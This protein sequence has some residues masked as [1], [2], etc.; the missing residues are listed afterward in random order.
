MSAPDHPTSRAERAA[1]WRADAQVFRRYGS[2]GRAVMLERLAAEWEQ[3]ASDDAAAVVDLTTAAS[4][5]GRGRGI[6]AA[7]CGEIV[8]GG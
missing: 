3:T 4:L 5:T 1:R 2:P 8:T 6:D 7:A